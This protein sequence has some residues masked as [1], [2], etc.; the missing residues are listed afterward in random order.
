MGGK[1]AGK[2]LDRMQQYPPDGLALYAFYAQESSRAK[3]CE[4][5]TR[6]DEAVTILHHRIKYIII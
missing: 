2:E 3:R 1:T 4:V 5:K 6:G